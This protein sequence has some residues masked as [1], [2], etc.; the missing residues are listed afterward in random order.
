MKD[1]DYHD[2]DCDCYDCCECGKCEDCLERSDTDDPMCKE[3]FWADLESR[4]YDIRRNH[5]LYVQLRNWGGGGDVFVKRSTL[6]NPTRI[7]ALRWKAYQYLTRQWGG[8]S[9][10]YDEIFAMDNH[11]AFIPDECYDHT[12]TKKERK[13]AKKRRGRR[14]PTPRRIVVSDDSGYGLS[15]T[16]DDQYWRFEEP[17]HQGTEMEV[18][19]AAGELGK[20]EQ[21]TLPARIAGI[22]EEKLALGRRYHH[23]QLRGQRRMTTCYRLNEL[24]SLSVLLT[25]VVPDSSDILTDKT[26]HVLLNGRRYPFITRRSYVSADTERWPQPDNIPDVTPPEQF[27]LDESLVGRTNEQVRTRLGQPIKEKDVKRGISVWYYPEGEVVFSSLKPHY[28][29]VKEVRVKQPA[30][31]CSLG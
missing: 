29:K 23:R 16:Y 12:R 22:S 7:E 15:L 3:D 1:P 11:E 14:P 27:E 31:A 28:G 13:A 26:V 9:T 25:G 4:G 6:S 30:G 5:D 10:H 2:E 18:I 8:S 20:W 19:A 17:K 21:V 24:L